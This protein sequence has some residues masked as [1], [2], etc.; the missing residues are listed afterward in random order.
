MKPEPRL[1]RGPGGPKE[2][3]ERILTTAAATAS[4]TATAAAP[5]H[6]RL[7]TDRGDVHDR[8]LETVYEN[9]EV[10]ERQLSPRSGFRRRHRE[11]ERSVGACGSGALPVHGRVIPT[12][13]MAP[14]SKV[15]PK[16]GRRTFIQ[17]FPP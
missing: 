3:L 4:S 6:F 14:A 7:F 5:A 1:R 12:P 17:L 8:R 9:A 2:E 16:T 10:G 15:A 13:T 11:H